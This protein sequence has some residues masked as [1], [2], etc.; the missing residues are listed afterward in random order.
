MAGPIYNEIEYVYTANNVSTTNMIDGTNYTTALN[1]T[2]QELEIIKNQLNSDE[3]NTTTSMKKSTSSF[4][5]SP[6][7]RMRKASCIKGPNNVGQWSMTH[8][9]P[10]KC[11]SKQSSFLYK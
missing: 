11:W 7:A 5:P 6:L 10:D 9:M 2:H 3:S 8:E 1:Q 4:T